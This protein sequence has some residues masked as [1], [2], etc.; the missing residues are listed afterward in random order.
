MG[1]LKVQCWIFARNENDPA[2]PKCL[3]LKTNLTRGSFWQPVTGS[4]EPGEGYFEAACREPLEETGFL[5]ESPPRDVGFEF[6]YTSQF[7]VTKEHV[8]AL[9]LDKE[10]IPK[11][12]PKEHQDFLWI[13]PID[14]LGKLKY[15]SNADGLK[16]SFKLIFGRDLN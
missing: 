11:L 12:D 5:F 3:L 14:A 1:Y 8:F 9:T 2:G 13:K 16:K 6:E 15:P 10:N 4:V 7:G